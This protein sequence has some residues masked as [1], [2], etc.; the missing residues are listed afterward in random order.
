[1]LLGFDELIG[2]V[3]NVVRTDRLI[4][5]ITVGSHSKL[6]MA[7][8]FDYTNLILIGGIG[9][10]IGMEFKISNRVY[11]FGRLRG[12]FDF[13]GFAVA[14]PTGNASES[15]QETNMDISLINA[16]GF[17]PNLGIGFRF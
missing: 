17:S 10:A 7:D 11:I 6:L 5:P 14:I 8:I 2:V 15:G 9:L 16:W 12:S 13:F 4:V 1:M 3:F